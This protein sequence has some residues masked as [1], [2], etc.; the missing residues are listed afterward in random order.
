M[1]KVADDAAESVVGRQLGIRMILSEIAELAL[2]QL[3]KFEV[4]KIY[5]N[6]EHLKIIVSLKMYKIFNFHS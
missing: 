1:Y 6:L 5:Q 2:Y 4:Y 3:R